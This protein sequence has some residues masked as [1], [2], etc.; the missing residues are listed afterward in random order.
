VHKIF[1]P[2]SN[3]RAQRLNPL[4]NIVKTVSVASSLFVLMFSTL[5]A[6]IASA[7]TGSTT[8]GPKS[9]S[10]AS[11]NAGVGTTAWTTPTN[12]YTSNGVYA[13]QKLASAAAGHYLVASA[14]GF[15]VPAGATVDGVTVDVQKNAAASSKSAIVDNSVKLV[16]AGVVTGTSQATTTVW[17]S[18]NS[19]VSYGGS[20]AAWGASLT[21][22]DVNAANFG[23]AISAKN[24]KLSG[25]GATLAANIDHI[26][27]SVSYTL[28]ATLNQASYGLFENQ[29]ATAPVNT[30]VFSHSSSVYGDSGSNGIATAD[31]NGDGIKDIAMANNASSTVSVL[32]GTG[33]GHYKDA[34]NYATGTNPYDIVAGDFSGDGKIDLATADFGANKVSILVNKG[35][36]TFTTHVEYSIGFGV[37]ALTA[38]DFN[39]DGRLDIATANYSANTTSVLMNLG[40]GTFA[41]TVNYYAGSGPNDVVSADF[42]GDG[43]ADL[44]VANNAASTIS[45]FTNSG[46]GT[47]AP[48]VDYPAGAGAYGINTADFNGDGKADLVT[49]NSTASTVSVFLGDGSG[50]FASK[51]DYAT[52]T[53]PLSVTTADFNG[54]GKADLAVTNNTDSTVSVLLGDGSGVFGAKTDYAT[55]YGPDA[56]VASDLDADGRID[57]ATVG[58]LYAS[59]SILTNGSGVTASPV[60]VGAALA[61][62]NTAATISA[63]QAFRL[64]LNV[65]VAGSTVAS[66]GQSFKL[67]Y[68]PMTTSCDLAFTNTPSSA[69][70]DVTS[71]STIGYYDNANAVN[72]SSF[73]ANANDPT[74]GS[75]PLIRQTYQES[76][77]SSFANASAIT[78]GQD[79]MWD[80]ALTSNAAPAGASYCLRVVKTAGNLN[81]YAVIPQVT[82]AADGTVSQ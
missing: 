63:N 38:A 58:Y 4:T 64:R 36:G 70:S 12:V 65:A 68:A 8:I 10:L 20:S 54:D 24:N 72:G 11:D 59:A 67:Q 74:D 5:L 22:A 43:K 57:L 66:A 26:R 34:V 39:G 15:S 45:I 9:A 60:D 75:N 81:S 23:V 27:I 7:A 33:A 48:K 19:Y 17:P 21:P 80:F 62:S 51:V 14:F 29:D 69:Y 1:Q 40:T 2:T 35:T 41:P 6:P 71:A 78:A 42:N 52:G 16:K 31:L 73:V 82:I 28:P 61:A 47:F 76:G 55:D 30:T 50:S 37:Q 53:D 25:T 79:G 77:T 32:I 49:T 3:I 13:T 46:T 56:I 18:S 44:A